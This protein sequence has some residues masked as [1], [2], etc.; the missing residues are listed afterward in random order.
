MTSPTLDPVDRMLLEELE[1]HLPLDH[2]PFEVLAEKVTISEQDCLERVIRLK[3]HGAIR[4]IGG[5][6]DAGALGYHEA[7][8]AMRVPSGRLDDAAAVLARYPGASSVQAR[9]DPFNLWCALAV[10][11]V[12]GLEQVARTL[13]TLLKAE[14]TI[15]LPPLRVYKA[16]TDLDLGGLDGAVE[17]GEP[18]TSRVLPRFALSEADIRVI[19]LLQEDLPLLE[20]PFAVW[21][22]QIE[23]T[24]DELFAWIKRME[25]VGVLRRMAAI[26]PPRPSGRP[27]TT[28]LVWQ[29]PGERVDMIGAQ[30]ALIRE[31]GYCC[32]RPVGPAWPYPLFTGIQTET[33]TGWMEVVQRIQE[34]IGPYPHKHFF[35]LKTYKKSRVT[36]FD[37]FLETWWREVGSRAEV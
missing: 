14:E 15:V 37:P 33:E 18:P 26:L 19:R 9:N 11:P 5:L 23:S 2:R 36:Y 3:A 28:T 29:I 20:L 25:H 10:P 1:R 8:L 34:R 6:F 31:V 7:L 22:E 13:E 17:D 32:Q 35:S 27:I 12:D 30:M 4:R 16:G 24:E 21:A